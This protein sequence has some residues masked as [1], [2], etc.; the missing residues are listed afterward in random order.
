M[1]SVKCQIKKR[2]FPF[3]TPSLGSCAG[4]KGTELGR[5]RAEE[6]TAGKYLGN[7]VAFVVTHDD[8]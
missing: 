1:Q 3:P 6:R 2:F 8:S 5:S 7:D 4:K